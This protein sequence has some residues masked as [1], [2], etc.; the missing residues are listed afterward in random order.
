MSVIDWVRGYRDTKLTSGLERVFSDGHNNKSTR[1]HVVWSPLGTSRLGFDSEFARHCSWQPPFARCGRL[2]QQ[3]GWGICYS[4]HDRGHDC[5]RYHRRDRCPVRCTGV[6]TFRSGPE[7]GFSADARDLLPPWYEEDPNNRVSPSRRWPCGAPQPDS[8]ADAFPCGQHRPSWLGR[9]SSVCHDGVPVCSAILYRLHATLPSV[10]SGDAPSGGRCVW[11]AALYPSNI[12]IFCSV[13]YSWASRAGSW[14]CPWA[15]GYSS[16]PPEGSVWPLC[17]AR[18]LRRWWPRVAP[19]PAYGPWPVIE[20][21]Q[22]VARSFCGRHSAQRCPLPRHRVT[23]PVPD[24]GHACEPP[25]AVPPTSGWPQHSSRSSSC[26]TCR[27]ANTISAIAADVCARRYRCAV[28]CRCCRGCRAM[29]C[30]WWPPAWSTATS[31]SSSSS[32]CRFRCGGAVIWQWHWDL[33]ISV[34]SYSLSSICLRLVP[35]SLDLSTF[36][37]I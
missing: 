37:H 19:C 22:S 29:G 4:R 9:P 20:V 31:P 30:A 18:L 28:R 7:R 25:E 12:P 5:P 23:A 24:S 32:P 13:G 35:F 11:F 26:S 34:V 6:P 3:V 10:W 21:L 8:G 17:R 15:V 16:P 14:C 1:Q 27:T 36:P 2:F 33:F